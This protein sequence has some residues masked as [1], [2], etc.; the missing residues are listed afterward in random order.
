MKIAIDISPLQS[1]HKVRGIGFYL[2]YLKSSL[3]QQKNK[4]TYIFFTQ[5]EKIPSDTDLVHYPY[6]E[7]FFRTL[8]FVKKLKTVVTVHDL[9]PLIFPKHFPSGIK[10]NLTWRV[11]RYLLR[12]VEAIITDSENSK[13]DIKKIIGYPENK[14]HVAYLAAGDEFTILKNDELQIKQIKMKYDLPDKF[15]LYVGD[16]TWNKNLPRLVKAVQQAKIPL[17]MI[18]KA[19]VNEQV[20]AANLWNK[21]IVEVQSLIKNDKNIICPGFVSTEE[22]VLL[23]NVATVFIMPSLYE[24]FGLPI[25]EAMSCGCPVVTTKEGSLSEVA[26]N[27]AYFVDA[28]SVDA[29]ATAIKTVFIDTKLQKELSQKGLI[30]AKKFS[31]EKTATQTTAVYDS[32]LK[33]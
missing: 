14:I 30:Q 6:F 4:Y 18:G 25:L 28:F 27:A 12:Q 10:G 31:W 11:Q 24:G 3:E 13:K 8:P 29:I 5:R 16:V 15:A 33:N 7:L 2:K 21:D 20:D 26:G 17:V 1:G 32:V 22:L 19:L 9:T 23:Y